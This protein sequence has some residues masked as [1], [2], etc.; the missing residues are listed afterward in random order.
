M[1]KIS[2]IDKEGSTGIARK[3]K[4]PIKKLNHS[5]LRASSYSHVPFLKPLSVYEDS[6]DAEMVNISSP[7]QSSYSN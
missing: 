2:K 7:K 3:A 6:L 5:E 4:L 1:G